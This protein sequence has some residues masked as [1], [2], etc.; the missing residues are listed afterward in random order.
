[1][2][3]R[4]ARRDAARAPTVPYGR[5]AEEDVE[6]AP[7]PIVIAGVDGTR[8]ALEAVRQATRLVDPGG[9]LLLVGVFDAW[10]AV[11][12]R[13]GGT[14]FAALD[15]RGEWTLGERDD[16]LRRR[17][18]ASLAEAAAQVTAPDVVVERRQVVGR[19]WEALQDAARREG[20][21]L[22]AVGSHGGSRVRGFLTGR[23][24]TDLAH[25]APCS[26]LI[27]RPPRDPARFP[28]TI[29]VGFDGSAHAEAAL[30]AAAAIAARH[31]GAAARVLACRSSVPGLLRLEV[32]P[33]LPDRFEF[34][35]VSA[36][37]DDGLIEAAE[38][39]DLLVVGSRGLRGVR[40]LGSTSERVAHGAACSVLIVRTAS[41]AG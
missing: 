24:A 28:A 16:A 27:A 33:R 1:M 19:P 36:L 35:S 10:D 14:S 31:P 40:T 5:A 6:M 37:P 17:I 25:A 30:A 26:V 8:A 20:A 9:R 34:A 21:A 2:P 32:E 12:G 3:S 15:E 7:Y 39:A 18:D 4:A 13:W 22:L 38:D 29:V 41:P 23:T 11:A